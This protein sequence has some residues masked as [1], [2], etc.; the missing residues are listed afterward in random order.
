MKTLL[1]LLLALLIARTLPAQDA[2][3][4]VR[5]EFRYAGQPIILEER[6][7]TSD[8]KPIVFENLRMYVSDLEICNGS[9]VV[10]TTVTQ[11]RLIDAE[12]ASQNEILVVTGRNTE[13]DRLRFKL[14]IDSLTN[15]SGA[16]GG[17]LDPTKGMYWAWQSG[18][19]NF[20]LEGTTPACPARQHRFQFHLGG[21]L[22]P[23]LALQAVELPI[24]PQGKDIVVVLAVDKLLEGI[25]LSKS[26]EVM[27][28]GQQAVDLARRVATCFQI[29]E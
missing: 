26:Y 16:L 27:S 15:V 12:N 28:P 24:R 23:F 9:Q 21:Y 14:G 11:H 19:I 10:A 17:D 13:M 1:V 5:F 29:A 7:A 6:Y 22:S 20:K 4:R 2:V 3:T 18:Y 8:G 25:D